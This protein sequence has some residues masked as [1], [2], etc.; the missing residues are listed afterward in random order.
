MPR[1]GVHGFTLME[2]LTVLA[3]MVILAGLVYPVYFASIGYAHRSS[4]A[5]NLQQI[6]M[7]TEL[8]RQD[9]NGYPLPPNYIGEDGVPDGGVTGLINAVNY[10]NGEYL[11]CRDDRYPLTFP[12]ALRSTPEA[13]SLFG[14]ER[15]ATASS[16]DFGYNYFGY[17]TTTEGTP[18]PVTT[19]EAA[20]Y[21]FGDPSSV[22]STLANPDWNLG[23]VDT[24]GRNAGDADVR[25]RG[26][27]QGLVNAWAPQN[28]LVTF[29][30]HHY[31]GPESGRRLIAVSLNGAAQYIAPIQPMF[32]PGVKLMWSGPFSRKSIS[33]GTTA[34]ID[35][36]VNTAAFDSQL[37]QN[38]PRLGDAPRNALAQ[39]MPVVQVTRCFINLADLSAGA[40]WY[41]TGIEVRPHDVIMVVARA[42]WRWPSFNPADPAYASLATKNSQF[43]FTAAGD[44][45][46]AKNGPEN[47]ALLLN[48]DLTSPAAKANLAKARQVTHGLL[49]GN[50]SGNSE[51]FLLGSRGSFIVPGKYLGEDIVPGDLLLAMN[52]EVGGTGNLEGWCEAW[53]ALYRP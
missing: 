21:F 13:I 18:F 45:V 26:L 14:L 49:I 46:E 47:F 20:R 43:W 39:H 3:I 25:P 36:R 7:T 37:Q 4:C 6:A 22:D 30:P 48:R 27:F 9:G 52:N 31:T 11:W 50:I 17:V 35:W 29:C 38:G 19:G 12:E 8:F 1:R 15:D 53:V 41:N 42:K 34:P 32:S 51:R 33:G 40:P 5:S 16:Y 10:R 24:A 23:V 44:P 2:L 28:T